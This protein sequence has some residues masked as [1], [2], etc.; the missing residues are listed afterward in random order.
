MSRSTR[1]EITDDFVGERH[2]YEPHRVGL[3]NLRIYV[4][5]LWRRRQFAYELS[6]SSLRSA[7]FDTAFGQLWLVLNPLL[8]GMVYFVLVNI[9][10]S[11][12]KGASFLAHLLSGLFAF[13]FVAG[14]IQTGARSVVG[15]GKLILNTAFP[16]VLLPLSSTLTAFM[17]FVPTFVVYAVIHIAAGLP[18]GWHLLWLAPI[19]VVLI[20][21]AL[22]ASMLFA[23]M[24][25]YFR[26]TSSFLPYFLRIWLYLSPILYLPGDVPDQF[27]LWVQ[28][29]PLFSNLSDL[30]R[31]LIDG[32]AP[33][34]A[35][36]GISVAWAV[37]A[38]A[39]G[40]LFFVSRE[41]EF[42]V[43]L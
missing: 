16:R 25:V 40:F 23:T 35:V 2:V 33:D 4:R 39:V 9:L 28:V 37:V 17:K 13:Y 3:P 27:K 22:G 5:E 26:D 14:A 6:S 1:G 21:F 7:H 41:R 12:A 19:L 36:F 43:R 20:T 10:S 11:N 29:N 42:A 18:F 38:F 31:V 30:S 8:L 32:R 15:G 34:L 24:Q